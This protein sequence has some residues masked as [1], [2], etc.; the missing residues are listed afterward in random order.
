MNRHLGRRCM[1]ERRCSQWLLIFRERRRATIERRCGFDR[2]Q[3]T[4]P[5]YG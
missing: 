3:R 2:R 1:A 4:A 5:A